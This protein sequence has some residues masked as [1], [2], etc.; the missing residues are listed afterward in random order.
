[1]RNQTKSG[2]INQALTKRVTELHNKGYDRD[3]CLTA[4]HQLFCVQNNHVFIKESAS[5][6]LID[7][8]YDRL[9]NH[10][11]YLHVV[12]SDNGERGILLLNFIHFDAVSEHGCVSPVN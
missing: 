7:Q 2:K 11:K 6:K 8:I 1:M 5:I 12:E 3:F 9:F 10:Y 4:N